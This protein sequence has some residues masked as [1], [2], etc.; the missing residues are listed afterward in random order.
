MGCID[1]TQKSLK[2]MYSEKFWLIFALK[3]QKVGS[4]LI[5]IFLTLVLTKR[6]LWKYPTSYNVI[7]TLISEKIQQKIY[8]KVKKKFSHDRER[9]VSK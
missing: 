9:I 4:G 2:K 3:K 7:Q 5:L 6:Q 8:S 1:L